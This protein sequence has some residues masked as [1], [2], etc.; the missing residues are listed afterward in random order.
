[1]RGKGRKRQG[2]GEKGMRWELKV[3]QEKNKEDLNEGT[4][5]AKER[6]RERGVKENG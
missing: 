1:M 6:G 3:K 5:E 2:K 4:T